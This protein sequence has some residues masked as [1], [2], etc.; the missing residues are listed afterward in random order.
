[1]DQYFVKAF[2]YLW[3]HT[4]P[5]ED[6]RYKGTWVDDETG[7]MMLLG[8]LERSGAHHAGSYSFQ[9]GPRAA[10]RMK[11]DGAYKVE[12]AKLYIQ[13]T[14]SSKRLR[15]LVIEMRGR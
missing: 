2:Q 10:I 13:A 14:E 6:C 15:N 8:C 4:Q 1:V 3:G 5:G 12:E 7:Q 11:L 9:T